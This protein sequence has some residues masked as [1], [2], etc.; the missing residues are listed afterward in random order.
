MCSLYCFTVNSQVDSR[1]IIDQAGADKLLVWGDMLFWIMGMMKPIRVQGALIDDDD[2]AKVTTF[3]VNSKR[4]NMMMKLLVC[5]LTQWQ[6]GIIVYSR[7]WSRIRTMTCGKDA[8]RVV[9]EKS[10][11]QY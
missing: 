7:Q 3:Y 11:S 4:Q 6:G 1:T 9:L 10:Q 8:V 5:P 2:E